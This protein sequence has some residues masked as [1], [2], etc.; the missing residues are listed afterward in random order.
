MGAYYRMVLIWGLIAR[1]VE[2]FFLEWRRVGVSRFERTAHVSFSA[3]AGPP[4]RKSENDLTVI[5]LGIKLGTPRRKGA[6]KLLS[7]MSPIY[8][9]LKD[10]TASRAPGGLE[11]CSLSTRGR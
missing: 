6:N 2:E 10:P 9:T 11:G 3:D 5:R 4:P 1:G 7:P 8:P